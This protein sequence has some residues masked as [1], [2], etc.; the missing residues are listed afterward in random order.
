MGFTSKELCSILR[1]SNK[2]GVSELT[3]G[4]LHVR[5]HPSGST[6]HVERPDDESFLA[7]STE[8]DEAP[9][10]GRMEPAD[11]VQ[12]AVLQEFAEAQTL[13]DD[14]A[15]YETQMIDE[16]LDLGGVNG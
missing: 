11:P 6:R 8:M 7:P 3:L 2:S 1:E 9:V 15:A 4:S 12:K 10:V 13:I 16:H 5:F 14:P